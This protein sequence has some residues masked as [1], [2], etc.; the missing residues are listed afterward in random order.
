[1]ILFHAIAATIGPFIIQGYSK[2]EGL[3]GASV[4]FYK[5]DTTTGVTTTNSI[6]EAM[7]DG[8]FSLQMGDGTV[9]VGVNATDGILS[10]QILN[11][12]TVQSAGDVT[13]TSS[14]NFVT[15]AGGVSVTG[16]IATTDGDITTGTGGITAG[17]DR[18]VASSG[19]I[20]INAPGYGLQLK[21]GANC[22]M[23]IT[24]LTGGSVVIPTSSVTA[25]SRIFLTRQEGGVLANVGNIGVTARSS[26]NSFTVTSV[27]VLD[28][29][30]FVWVIVEP[31]P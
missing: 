24:N 18:G 5:T 27:N 1:M 19:P 26:G 28:T 12:L 10:C 17:G 14:G 25:N 6:I 11:A 7:Q 29:E 21:E 15:S 2:I 16:V 4:F 3:D 8:S 13:I 20:V 23:G 31:A 9:M 22:V 30:T